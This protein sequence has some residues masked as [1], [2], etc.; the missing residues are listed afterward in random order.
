MDAIAR[1]CQSECVQLAKLA[2]QL[3]KAVTA[4]D[5]RPKRYDGP[6]ALASALLE[7]EGVGAHLPAIPIAYEPLEAARGAYYGGRIECARFG[8]TSAPVWRYDLIS[9]YPWAAA[10]LPSLATGR[11]VPTLGTDAFRA[12]W[13]FA[14]VRWNFAQGP[15]NAALGAELGKLYPFAW[16]DPMDGNVF[17]PQRG[18]AWTTLWELRSALVALELGQLKGTIDVVEAWRWESKSDVQPFGWI[19][20]VFQERARLK[21][22]H[23]PAEK[24]LKLALNSV[25][26]KLAQRHTQKRRG[27]DPERPKWHCLPWAAWVTGMVRARLYDAAL[28]AG[29]A[30]IMI[31]TDAIFTTRPIYGAIV[32]TGLGD[33]ELTEARGATIV[34]SGVYWLDVDDEEKRYTRGFE[35]DAIT[36]DQVLDGWRRSLPKLPVTDRRFVG[37]RQAANGSWAKRCSWQ[38]DTSGAR[39]LQLAPHF[40]K[41]WLGPDSS[42]Y[43]GRRKGRIRPDEQLIATY[44]QQPIFC[45]KGE[46]SAPLDYPWLSTESGEPRQSQA[47][48]NDQDDAEL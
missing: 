25:Y 40:G 19:S 32:G 43:F 3:H 22:A 30:L 47:I 6:G 9:A 35:P 10:Q 7:R 41:R 46:L 29:D 28:L 15:D 31:A 33:W 16:R 17:F 38:D 42:G 2:E 5:L 4:A 23:D 13:G 18:H 39:D 11:W 8:H 14:R 27:S 20:R 26:G 12:L 48:Y 45:D 21:A 36:R 34:Q 44:A 24:V 37:L 1:Y